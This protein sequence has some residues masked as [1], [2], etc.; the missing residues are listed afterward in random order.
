MS[1]ERLLSEFIG[2]LFLVCTVVGSGIMA[3]NL[4]AGN[5]GIALLGN[6]IATGAILVVLITLFAP[7]SGAHFNP[8][9]SLV[10]MVLQEM[11]P[12]QAAA[13]MGMQIGGGLVGTALAHAMFNVDIIQLSAN[14]RSGL[15]QYGA[16]I[17]AT[18]GLVL[19]I[20]V[21]RRSRTEA[22]PMLVGLYI[23]AAYFSYLLLINAAKDERHNRSNI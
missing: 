14:A 9:V 7:I 13:Y 4:S 6:T 1:R 22:I 2:T 15:P 5:D 11:K 23:M 3:A 17:V 18:F 8:V 21:G 20:L 12:A 19:V 10:M 16:E